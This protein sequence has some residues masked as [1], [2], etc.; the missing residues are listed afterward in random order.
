MNFEVPFTKTCH[1]KPYAAIDP[2]QPSLS[3]SGKTILITAGH[4]GIGF[5][6]AQNF[7]IAGAENIILLAR[8][9]EVLERAAKDLSTAHPKTKFHHFAASIDDTAMVREIFSEINSTISDIDILVTSAA[10]IASFSDVLTLPTE[11]LRASFETN[12]FGNINLVKEFLVDIP[13]IGSGKEKIILDLSSAAAHLDSPKYGTYSV[14][15]MA[16]SRWL[17]HLHH[18]LKDKAVRIHSYHPGGVFTE[19]AKG[20]G[21]KEDSLPWDDVELPGQFSVWLASKEAAFLNGRFV[22]ANWDVVELKAQQAEFESDPYILTLGL[23][24]S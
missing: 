23:I 19:A 8:R 12:I 3:A 21:M 7:A 15:K 13:E 4:T 20:F 2:T 10:Y 9:A 16:F 5:A 17:E 24:S 1:K 22:W 6:I 18:D 14:S 11:Q